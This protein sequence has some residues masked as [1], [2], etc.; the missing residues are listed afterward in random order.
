MG[1]Y[2]GGK[3]FQKLGLA[4]PYPDQSDPGRYAVTKSAGDEMMFKVPSLRNVEKTGP[5]FHNGSARSLPEAVRN[6]AEYQLGKKLTDADVNSIVAWL[7]TLTGEIP[8][9]YVKP[10]RLPKS[11]AA[12]PKPGD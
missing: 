12:T 10:P 6:M 2:V 3:T 5:Y 4:K 9:D 11:T 8:A 1:P 7:K